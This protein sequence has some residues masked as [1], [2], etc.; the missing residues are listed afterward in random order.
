M[1]V[2]GRYI[3]INSENFCHLLA[4]NGFQ[5]DILLSNSKFKKEFRDSEQTC[6]SKFYKKDLA[7]LIYKTSLSNKTSLTI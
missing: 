6:Y 4:L 2:S 5:S 3:E 7:T 1:L